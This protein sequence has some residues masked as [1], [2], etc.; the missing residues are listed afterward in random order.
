MANMQHK[1]I[2]SHQGTSSPL[3]CLLFTIYQQNHFSAVTEEFSTTFTAPFGLFT[4]NHLTAPAFDGTRKTQRPATQRPTSPRLINP[5][6][7]I[8]SLIHLINQL[9]RL[10]NEPK[11]SQFPKNSNQEPLS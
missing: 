7:K 6:S 10:I 3:S 4:F 8:Q 1:R 5:L 11:N 9:M 2:K